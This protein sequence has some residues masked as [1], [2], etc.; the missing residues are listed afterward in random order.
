MKQGWLPN[1]TISFYRYDLQV[2]LLDP[3]E[4]EH[5]VPCACHMTKCIVIKTYMMQH[6]QRPRE[7]RPH[8]APQDNVL[9]EDNIDNDD[10]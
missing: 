7:P 10:G 9:E 5:P 3:D 2:T 8:N 1:Y 6:P 4:V